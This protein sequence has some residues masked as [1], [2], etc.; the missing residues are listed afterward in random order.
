MLQPLD[1]LDAF[2]GAAIHH[3]V[4]GQRLAVAVA[5][6]GCTCG[7]LFRGV[8]I[9]GAR[10][11]AIARFEPL[12]QAGEAMLAEESGERFGRNLV[13]LHVL[14]RDRQAAIFAQG[15]QNAAQL[16]I[17]AVL[18]QPFLELALLHAVGRVERSGQPAVFGNQLARGLG[19]NPE[20]A[21][22]VV[23]RIAHEREHVTDFFGSDPE[24]FLDLF[25]VDA[26]V[27]HR[28]EHVDTRAVLLAD[29]LHEVLVG[30]H[31]GDVPAL[32]LRRARIGCDHVVR[33]DIGFLD[34]GQAERTRGIANQRELRHQVFGRGW[35]IGLVLIVDL[36]AEAVARLVE[37][38]RQMGRAVGL[39]QIVG[40]LPQH[41]RVTVNRADRRPFGIGQRGEAVVG[42]EDVGR[43]VDEV[44]MR[45][46]THGEAA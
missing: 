15:H 20:D 40:K 1:R 35:A 21:G 4:I 46:F 6:G 42:T 28:V 12:E 41:G 26:G 9:G 24:L 30:R 3:G 45:C 27:L 14:E 37:N 2:I 19:A 13:E 5:G 10:R 23:D 25:D 36:V 33:L 39:V 38:H 44:E 22:D 43:A 29:E 18:D 32:L 7:V 16:R 17:R 8:E 11:A 31:D 34:A